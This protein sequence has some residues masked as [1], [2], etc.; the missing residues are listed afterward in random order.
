MA[1]QSDVNPINEPLAILGKEELD[2]IDGYVRVD[3]L[4][5]KPNCVN[6]E[7]IPKVINDGNAPKVCR[8]F[9]SGRII[10]KG[11]FAVLLNERGSRYEVVGEGEW[12]IL[13]SYRVKWIT[14]ENPGYVSISDG[15]CNPYR[16]ASITIVQISPDQLGIAS[17]DGKPVILSAGIHV[18]NDFQFKFERFAS[19]LDAYINHR[20][21]HII[22]V[23]KGMLAKVTCNNQPH[24]LPEGTHC[25]RLPLFR[26]DGQVKMTDLL[27]LYDT[28]TR[29]QVN[30]G[31]I[32]LAWDCNEP[33]LIDKP[34]VYVRNSA[35]FVFEKC[36][37]I[38]TKRIVLGSVQIII[39]DPG[40]VGIMFTPDLLVLEPGIHR[41]SDP[42]YSFQG[43][44]QTREKILQLRE[45]FDPN[46]LQNRGNVAIICDTKE[47]VQIGIKADIYYRI[48]D[49]RKVVLTIGLGNEI[50]LRMN[51]LG[52]S[53]LNAIARNTSLNEIAQ[54]NLTQANSGSDNGD[55]SSA[56]ML[57]DKV[58][59]EFLSSL[60]G[61]CS[62]NYGV[63]L[64]NIRI[65]SFKIMNQELAS[66][67]S[68]QAIILAET[69]TEL[70][71]LRGKAE[72]ASADQHR[73][74]EVKRIESES[75]ATALKLKTDAD[76]AVVI[77][78]AR[79][80]AEAFVIEANASAQALVRQREAEAEALLKMKDAEA[81]AL[82]KIKHAEAE[83]VKVL[84]KA[85][86]ERA[87]ML[88]KT[89]LGREIAMGEI[90]S[91]TMTDSLNGVEK[92]VYLPTEK[93][94]FSFLDMQA[95]STALNKFTGG[96]GK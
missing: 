39:V 84:A 71:N 91:K 6:L 75:Y 38:T 34:G 32:A 52:K 57:F 68:S 26:Y 8:P 55:G 45:Q 40:E 18:Y 70:A 50:D 76:N 9:I 94:M 89:S 83:G 66:Q 20:D 81:Q 10:P 95:V 51:E 69:E 13:W 27:I 37:P 4:L 72:I 63:E 80:K 79:A 21:V 82:L 17:Q 41:F 15:K 78:T 44:L 49:P 43:T 56:P 33:C 19:V 12:A 28:I 36:V 67:I 3:S 29:F 62:A 88:Q 5:T 11:T 47:F 16:E 24:L 64:I 25:F 46:L 23:G 14:P 90:Y 22:Q 92:V 65:E 30:K 73:H 31:E 86:A 61:N 53:T 59:D 2:Q 1:S 85:E 35:D 54:S 77:D 87:E 93:G 42:T 7:S 58:H 48:N 74:A 60:A 96:T